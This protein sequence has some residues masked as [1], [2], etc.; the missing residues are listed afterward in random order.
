VDGHGCYHV[1]CHGKHCC[2]HPH[3]GALEEA[4]NATQ[5]MV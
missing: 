3:H 2:V 1:G 4:S 5:V